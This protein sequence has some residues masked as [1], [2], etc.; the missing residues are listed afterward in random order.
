MSAADRIID[1]ASQRAMASGAYST[2]VTF[3]DASHAGGFTRYAT[4][5][6]KLIEQAAQRG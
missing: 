3:D 6:V 2:V 1:P 4:R 5:F